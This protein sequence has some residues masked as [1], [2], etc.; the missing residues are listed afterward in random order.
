MRC[1]GKKIARLH[2]ERKGEGGWLEAA[3]E[4][5]RLFRC[6]SVAPAPLGRGMRSLRSRKDEE[7]PAA[8]ETMPMREVPG[9]LAGGMSSRE[10]HADAKKVFSRGYEQHGRA[11]DD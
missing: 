10:K 3:S 8:A 9:E 6:A 4:M 5:V 7:S 11:R 1:G 2:E